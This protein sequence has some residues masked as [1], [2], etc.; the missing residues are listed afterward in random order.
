MHYYFSYRKVL[1][2]KSSN[3]QIIDKKKSAWEQIQREFCAA[4]TT[5]SRTIPQLKVFYKNCKQKLR[6]EVAELNVGSL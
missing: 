4:S 5:G 1:E 2:D 6:K 3:I